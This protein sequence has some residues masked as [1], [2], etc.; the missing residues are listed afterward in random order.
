MDLGIPPSDNKNMFET[1]PLKFILLVVDW[2]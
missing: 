1:N 2:S